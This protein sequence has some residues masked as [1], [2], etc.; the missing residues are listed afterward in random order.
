MGISFV[1]GTPSALNYD[2]AGNLASTQPA[3]AGAPVIV[4]QPIDLLGSIG[5]NASISVSVSSVTA[6]TYQWK[7]HG[8]DIAGATGDTLYIPVVSAA[9]LVDGAYTVV[10]TN[11]YGS[12]T[13]APASLGTVRWTNLAGGFWDDPANW[14][15]GSVPGPDNYVVIDVPGNV[16]ITH[17]QGTS[18]IAVL[19][20]T[21]PIVVSGGVLTVTGTFQAGNTVTLAGGT[22]KGATITTTGNQPSFVTGQLGSALKFDGTT[23]YADFG[24]PADGHLDMG[25]DA[26][27]ETWVKFSG[28]VSATSATFASKDE[29][30]GPLNKWIFGYDFSGSLGAPGSTVFYFFSPGGG[31]VTM[32]S[33]AWMP[34]IGQWYHLA[35]V[36]SGN[37]F[38]FYRDGV[39]DG[40]ATATAAVPVV[41]AAFI[42]GQAENAF[43]LNGALDDMRLWNVARTGT[44]ISANRNQELVGNEAGLAGYWK[45]NEGHGTSLGDATANATSGR[46]LGIVPNL[47]SATGG[48]LDGV[49]LGSDLT[50]QNGATL[51]VLGGLT[52][53]NNARVTI[54]S[55]D[56]WTYLY[57]QGTQT[58]GGTGEV[59][60]GGTH[61][62]NLLSAQ[63]NGSQTGAAA[64]TI[65]S[66]ITVHGPQGGY[67]SGY[68]DNDSVINHGRID[69]DTAD[70]TVALF[71]PFFSGTR[72]WSNVGTLA[73]SAGTLD[74]RGI[75]SNGGLI[76][77][78]GSGAVNLGG[79][80]TTA[81]TWNRTGGTLNITGMLDNTAAALNLNDA[82]GTWNLAGGT[83]KGG[84]INGSG[85]SALV[86]LAGNRATLDGVRLNTDL[87]VQNNATLTVKNGLMLDNDHA[88]TLAS[89]GNSTNLTFQGTQTLAGLGQVVFGGTH[90]FNLLSAQGNGSQ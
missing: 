75:W 13:S 10:V 51:A 37:S 59:V 27:I 85:G 30:G 53:S 20:T 70:K 57:F 6:V 16:T 2:P 45:F 79:T 71:H 64:L 78:S 76:A 77:L 82:P 58:L 48:T 42:L 88:L 36:K 54:A 19:R 73:A 9:D 46:F 89:E 7:F 31:N 44:D 65:G 47:L 39:A 25:T 28:S 33:N 41:N 74:L 83:I 67:V 49:T 17:R 52:L 80:F 1:H 34:V 22:I 62:F 68:F 35:V 29:G 56:S 15:T 63:G 72:S 12:V 90:S 40:T 66:G 50:V 61:S 84:V 32:A 87:T 8:T 38:T 86:L 24:N 18:I 4:T 23:N 26:T 14:S 11:D 81:G 3:T 21:N 5:G 69:A 60:F 55:A 43:P